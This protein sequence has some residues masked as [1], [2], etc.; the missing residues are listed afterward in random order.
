MLMEIAVGNRVGA[1]G[2]EWDVVEIVPLGQQTML[3]LRCAAGDL[4][5]LEWELLHPAERI[6]S[7]RG[8]LC[9]ERRGPLSA[10]LLCHRAHLL[11]QAAGPADMLSAEPG[12]VRIEP[13]QL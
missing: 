13:F 2:L 7:V 5:G 8:E 9:P 4:A 12:R 10:W 3:R 6:D 11:Q 1:R